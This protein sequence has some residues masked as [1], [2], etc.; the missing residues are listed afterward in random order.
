M[1]RRLLISSLATAAV[2]ALAFALRRLARGPGGAAQRAPQLALP[3]AAPSPIPPIQPSPSPAPA[4]PARRR[5]RGPTREE[6][7]AQAQE[8]G[9]KGRSKMTKAQLQEAI[10]RHREGDSGAA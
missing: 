1:A 3:E 5:R 8:L 9:I 4:P 6:L 7:Y 2:G 10:Q